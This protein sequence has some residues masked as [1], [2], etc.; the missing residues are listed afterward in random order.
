MS[1]VADQVFADADLA[2]HDPADSSTGPLKRDLVAGLEKGLAVIAAFDQERPRLTISEVAARTGLTRAAA[3]RYLLTLTHLGFVSQDRKMF[4]LTAKVLRLGQSYLHSARLPRIVEPE[5]Q[6]LA[7]TLKEASIAGVL[8]GDDVICIAATTAGRVV[9]PAPQPG[10]RVPAYASGLGRVLLAAMPQAELETFIARQ[11]FAP[12]TAHSIT[13]P[14]RLRQ[15]IA[16][17]RAQGYAC[18]DQELEVGLRT[19]AVPLRNYRGEVVSAMNVLVHSSRMSIEQM[20]EQCLPS[21]LHTQ[22][23]LRMLL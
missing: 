22:A 11:D 4:S 8:D 21:M 15:E 19:L 12:L 13:E 5:L 20:V 23:H 10:T 3:R 16:R 14:E 7:Y 2:S 9:G 1:A 6:K 17:T 18:I